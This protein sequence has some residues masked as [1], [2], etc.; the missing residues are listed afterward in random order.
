MFDLLKIA[1]RE[2]VERL[3]C[4]NANTSE[5]QH[6]TSLYSRVRD[7]TFIAQVKVIEDE[8]VLVRLEQSS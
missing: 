5:K 6:F 8:I 2:Q 4:K 7:S 3:Y 1:C